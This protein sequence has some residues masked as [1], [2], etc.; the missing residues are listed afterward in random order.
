MNDLA[1]IIVNMMAK[2]IILISYE[3]KM[4]KILCKT[5]DEFMNTL[6]F[7]KSIVDEEVQDEFGFKLH[8]ITP[9]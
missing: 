1:L 8:Y 2:K 3:G 6:N 5:C 9:E 7:I 4:K